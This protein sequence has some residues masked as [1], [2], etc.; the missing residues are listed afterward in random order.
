MSDQTVL[1]D[2]RSPSQIAAA[3]TLQRARQLRLAADRAVTSNGRIWPRLAHDAGS[4]AP[5]GQ[6][7]ELA[8]LQAS[9]LDE[10]LARVE[11]CAGRIRP[12][13]GPRARLMCGAGHLLHWL[14][15]FDGQTWD[16]RW[17]NSGMDTAPR[18][19]VHE[20]SERLGVSVQRIGGGVI[21]MVLARLV[22]PSY[23]WLLS[24]S[25]WK[26]NAPTAFLDLAGNEDAERVRAL[27][28][29]G[30]AHELGRRNAENAIARILIRTGKHLHQLTAEDVL[31][32]SQAVRT[33]RN[34]AK[35]HLAW[36]LLVAL[37]PLAGEP[38]TLR[39][40][41]HAS[42][43]SRR[44]TVAMLVD[45]YAIPASPV[46]DLLVDYLEELAPNMDYGSLSGLAYRLVRLFW[47]EVIDINPDQTDLRLSPAV[48][49]E[50]RQRIQTTLEGR[51]RTDTSSTFF[52]VRALYR[53]LAEWSYDD[54][55]RWAAWVAPTPLP[56]SQSRAESKR[57][58]KV[59]AR[60][61]QRTRTLAPLLPAFLLAASELRD[62]GSMLLEATLAAEHG[63]EYTLDGVTYRRHDP[64][65]RCLANE[66]ARVWAEVVS[67]EGGARPPKP[68]GKRV[69]VSAVEAD[70]FWGWAIASTLKETGIRSEELQELTQ[71]SLRHYTAPSTN[72]IVP[73]LHI[74]PSKTD[75]ER[76]IPMSPEL[77]KVL[78][79]VQR[80]A[81][82]TGTTVPLSIRYD[83]YEKTFGDPLPHLFARIVGPTQNTLSPAYIRSVLN[84]IAAHAGITDGGAPINFTPHDFRRL[85]A[86]DL[87]GTGLP[88]HIVA[89]L[90]GHLN[91]ETTRGYTAVFPE[92][93]IQAHHAFIERRRQTRPD[94]ELRPATTE[95][96]TDF[97]QRFL[98]R[99]IALGA[100]HRPY[101]TPCIHE[102]ACIKCRF[103]QVDPAQAGRLEEMTANAEQ[104]L[105]EAREHRWLGEV[106][107]L[108]ESLVHLR[109]RRAE[110]Q[111]SAGTAEP[112]ISP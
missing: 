3:Q 54:P 94:G 83:S 16:E 22:R 110:A 66:R 105:A 13:P 96:W 56:R 59:E 51:E 107:A 11:E 112:A 30:R 97:E 40:A 92:H 111:C 67:A 5:R 32:Y 29:Y 46:R 74:A 48:A 99:R 93:V 43:T 4:P 73:L 88:L 7:D 65:T 62:R 37:G 6:D 38:P 70:G 71:L 2:P 81:R 21:G 12:N 10:A 100:C 95:E 109:R 102:H 57:R 98:L 36:E 17:R 72:T 78:V 24:S 104:R 15:A 55:G 103:L 39:A 49:A 90:L 106:S 28:E 35:E 61:H 18:R 82:G 79:D 60:M 34:H 9:T 101:A 50:W 52:A 68:A 76:L 85:F 53:D 25:L 8:R 44:H 41:W 86:T 64:P 31:A 20:L 108:E 23:E 84:G 87:V 1:A 63:Q 27:P 77:V 75:R 26:P 80:R 14:A 42:V 47:A 45:R 89:T 69:D 19:G 91:L 33:S 58:R